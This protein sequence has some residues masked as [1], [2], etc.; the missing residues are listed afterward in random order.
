M[1]TYARPPREATRMKQDTAGELDPLVSLL[2]KSPPDAGGLGTPV[3][4]ARYQA[5]EAFLALGLPTRKDENWRY[6]DL[7][8]VR[9]TAFR[10]ATQSDVFRP[11]DRLPRLLGAGRGAARLV[12]VNGGFRADLSSLTGLPDGFS[13]ASLAQQPDADRAAT[14]AQP[15]GQPVLRG[16]GSLISLNAAM[17][18][19]GVVISVDEAAAGDV[20]IEIVFV[21]GASEPVAYALRNTVRVGAGARLGLIEHHLAVPEGAAFAN[22][23][24]RVE[25]ENGACL[26]HYR[27]VEG[28]PGSATVTTSFADV[29]EDAQYEAFSLSVGGGLNR[30]E[31]TV[32][33]AGVRANCRI[34]GA[35]AIAGSDICDN[36]TMVAHRAPKTTSRQVFRGVVDDRA[37]AVF[38][39]RVIV[40]RAAQEADGHQLSKVLLLSP[41][42]EIDQKPALEIFADNV[43]CSHGAAAGQLDPTAMFYLR[44]RGL[45]EATARQML[46]EGFLAEVLLEVS[47]EEVRRQL[48]QRVLT[49]VGANGR[50]ME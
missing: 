36:T 12:F 14:I 20:W 47:D 50:E 26:H 24:M 45:P 40:D 17:A 10:M 48:T 32:E 44:S 16:H 25:L 42:A 4:D 8:L 33:L 43:K 9:R 23:V 31:T 34:G 22:A 11:V 49:A 5:R 15:L 21:G 41:A 39:G 13:A 1:P 38:Q 35:Y 19:D 28:N 30:V 7:A 3:A 6:T 37:H 46:L 18:D 29:G 2:L 27:V